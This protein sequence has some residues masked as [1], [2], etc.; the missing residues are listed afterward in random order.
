MTLR[1]LYRLERRRLLSCRVIGVA[2]EGWTVEHLR[3]HARE[4]ITASGEKLDARLQALRR[5]AGLRRRGLRRSQPLP[6][7]GHGHRQRQEPAFYLEIPPSLF[8]TVVAG[9]AGADLVSRGRRVA[10]EKPF[11]HDLHPPARSPPTCTSTSTSL[12][13]TGSITSWAR[14]ASRSS[15]TCVSPTRR[16]SRF[17]TAATSARC[18]SR[19]P[20][21]SVSRIAA[22]SMTRSARCA[23][24]SSTI[25]CRLVAAAA[26]EP[27]AAGDPDSLK[28]AKVAVFRSMPDGRARSTTSA[29]VHRL[30]PGPRGGEG[31]DTE[32]YA[33]L[34]LEIDNWRWAGVPFFIR[35]GKRCPCAQTELRLVFQPSAAPRLPPRSRRQPGPS[36]LIS[37]STP[38]T[39]IQMIARRPAGR[40]ARR[41]RDRARH[42]VRPGGRRGPTPYEVLLHAVLVGD[43]SHFTRQDGIEETW[44]VMSRCSIT[45]P[46]PFAIARARGALARPTSWCEPRGL[47]Q[48][49]A[50]ALIARSR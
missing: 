3:K 28:D 43:S 10:V 47:A 26:M 32:T 34:R 18:R 25:S 19:W 36:E 7:A 50:R 1:S 46:G 24:W 30:P 44:R 31:L 40:Y 5:P 14:W 38:M 35:A 16:S 29:A 27:P 21:T 8:A 2:A 37:A 9:L 13:C 23:T 48:P 41:E 22:T 15:S 20:R 11:G 17:G 45:R 12:S 42:G 6:A 4:A 49:L 39:G 33:A